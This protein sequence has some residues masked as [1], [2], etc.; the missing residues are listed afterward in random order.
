MMKVSKQEYL[1]MTQQSA[2]KSKIFTNCLKAFV[3]GGLICTLGQLLTNTF[4]QFGMAI[5]D[6]RTLTTVTLIFLG[7]LL[8]TLGWY[9][10]IAKHAGA[11]SLVP[12]TGFSNAVV[13]P[14]IEFKAEGLILGL[15]AKMFVIAGPVLVYSVIASIVYGIIY[16]IF[17]LF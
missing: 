5:K 2:P 3:I 11:G 12:V 13:S 1:K 6:S 17:T 9:D 10:N 7:A 14:A 4:L 8:T 16:Y 15:G